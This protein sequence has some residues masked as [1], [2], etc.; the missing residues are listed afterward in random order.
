MKE[1]KLTR[2]FPVIDDEPENIFEEISKSG[3]I[4]SD[5]EEN[6]LVPP[7][8]GEL[9]GLE[10]LYSLRE[11]M[12]SFAKGFGF[13]KTIS[14]YNDKAK[15]LFDKELGSLVFE[16]MNITPSVAATLQ[17]WQFLNMKLV[18]DLVFWR[19]GVSKDHFY[20]VRRNY[21]GTQWWRY[22]LFKESIQ[23]YQSLSEST[24]A[25]LYERPGTRGLPNHI[26]NIPWWYEQ[27]TDE[28]N[29]EKSRDNFRKALMGY[30]AELGF[31]CY[32]VLSDEERFALYKKIF[33][34]IFVG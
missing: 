25:D 17:M 14:D 18:P 6:K 4:F 27:L 9:V 15:S 24:I 30:N 20:D 5:F 12:I 21:L 8:V 3:F 23:L 29:I 2:V 32:F 19:W 16:R 33:I 34:N 7:G 28:Y 31:K 1:Y 26:V 10:E 22:Y 13:P 11:Q